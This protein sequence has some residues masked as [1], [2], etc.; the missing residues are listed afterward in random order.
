M[1]RSLSGDR[2]FADEFS[3]RLAGRQLIKALTVLRAR[4]GLSQQ[5]LAERLGCT[6]SKVSKLESSD[7]A[8]IRLGDLLAYTGAVRHEVRILL[9]PRGQ[10][11]VDEVRMH[12]LIIQRLLDRIVRLAGDDGA[13]TEGLAAFLEEAALNLTRVVRKA[14]AALPPIPEEPSQ[15][16]QVEA[17]RMDEEDASRERTGDGAQDTFAARPTG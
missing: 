9:V 17:P 12:A 3:E 1:V 13:M 14:A 16:L 15:A 7:D 6:Q 5:E 8:D 11:I 4:A 10:R 2:A